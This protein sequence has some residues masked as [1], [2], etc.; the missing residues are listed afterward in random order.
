M[1]MPLD[2]IMKMELKKMGRVIWEVL[3][4]YGYVIL[5]IIGSL[6]VVL[7]AWAKYN[8]KDRARYK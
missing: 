3:S 8:S 6:A 1:S 2:T 7:Y 4:D 5:T